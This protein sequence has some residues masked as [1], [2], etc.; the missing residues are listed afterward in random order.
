MHIYAAAASHHAA[1]QQQSQ[2][3]ELRHGAYLGQLIE[4]PRRCPPLAEVGDGRASR[5]RA[6]AVPD[7]PPGRPRADVLQRLRLT[8]EIRA[9]RRAYLVHES[10]KN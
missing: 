6:Q 9:S 5:P 7:T 10:R 3:V 8:A 4:P 2:L 1:T